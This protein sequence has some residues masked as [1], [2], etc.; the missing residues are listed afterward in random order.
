MTA[1][2]VVI[3]GAGS[4]GCVLAARLSQDA[5]REVLLVEAGPDYRAADLPAD[6]K[7]GW[8]GPVVDPYDWGLH[9]R[10]GQRSVAIPRGRVVGGCSSTNATFALRGSPAD[11][12]AWNLPGWTFD[13]V[14]P[15]FVALEHDLDYA[16]A[17]YHG[18]DGPLPI[19]RYLDSERSAV[20]AA[21]LKAMI[22]AGLPP[23]DDHN[24]PGAVGAGPLPVNAVDGRRISAALSHLEPARDR[25][26]LM[27]RGSSQVRAVEISRGRAVGVR[28]ESDEVI[29]AAEVIV[30]TGTYGSPALLRNSG[31]TSPAIGANLVDHPAV[32]VDLPYHG[33]TTDV[34]VFQL[35]A[36]LRSSLADP[37]TDPPDLQLLVGGP[38]PGP[39]PGFFIGAAVMKPRSRGRVGAEIDLN[40]YADPI[41]LDR[42][43]EGLDLV[44][45]IV[46]HPSIARLTR[47]ERVTPRLAGPDLRASIPPRTW[48]YHHPVGTCAIG[49]VV[50]ERCRVPDVDN[51]SVVD[52][53]VFPDVPSANTNLPTMM[54]AE[55]IAARWG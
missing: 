49:A 3:V 20:A 30:S 38:W 27:V 33:P 11:Y 28:L 24:A 32:S 45:S 23:I 36:T 43:M 47:T 34:A 44:E 10:S 4:A 54:I 46:A 53:S 52:A 31:L 1:F 19:R 51:L 48:S 50:D 6:L 29:P 8:H 13:E 21:A 37:M 5:A 18:A 40:Y 22:A 17:E 9:A 2:D 14:L 7:D 39:T 12:D 35:V 42:M 25:P 15:H 41:D 55:R 26:N 16:A